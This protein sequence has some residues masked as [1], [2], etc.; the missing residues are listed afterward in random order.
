MEATQF[1]QGKKRNGKMVL[2]LSLGIIPAEGKDKMY[3]TQD[4]SQG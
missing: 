1:L 2:F 3:Q 4:D